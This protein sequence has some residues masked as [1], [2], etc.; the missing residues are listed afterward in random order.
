MSF[1]VRA[2]RFHLV[3]VRW[4]LYLT[5]FLFYIKTLSDEYFLLMFLFGLNVVY[6]FFYFYRLP[7]YLWI[8]MITWELV[9]DTLLVIET[10]QW[11]SPFVLYEYTTLLWL[12]TYLG[13]LWLFTVILLSLGSISVIPYFYAHRLLLPERSY[14][15][16]Q[17][18]L[19]TVLCFGGFFFLHYL[20]SQTK[21]LYRQ[22]LFLLSFLKRLART[23]HLVEINRL[24]EGVIKKLLGAKQAYVCWLHHREG[25][26][27]WVRAY[28]TFALVES[29]IIH[30]SS[31][32]RA[33]CITDYMG[34]L[35]QF[36][37]FPLIRRNRIIGAILISMESK[38]LIWNLAVLILHIIAISILN[39]ERYI[40]MRQE[41]ESAMHRE[42]RTKMAQDMHDGLAQQLF[43]L[44]AQIFHYKLNLP[45]SVPEQMKAAI[46][47][48]E[49]Q[50][51][52]C[53]LEVR[54]Y[55]H[56][57]RND[58]GEGH[59]FDAIEQLLH[60]LTKNSKVQVNYS[61]KGH[62]LQESLEVEETVYRF[63]EE[64]VYNVLKHAR[65]SILD[66]SLEV[67]SV[68]W[69]IRIK[70]DGVG[71]SP[72]IVEKKKESYGVMGMKDRMKRFGGVLSI[73]SQPNQG[74]EI[75]AIIP[76][77]GGKKYA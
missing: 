67:T 34:K 3:I 16:A 44:S 29:G 14:N 8:I 61:T 39:Q 28:Y 69:T 56:H 25:S 27:D 64:A 66:V 5:A 9:L 37:Y 22:I 30:N 75:V 19:Q 24:T 6:T 55:I 43:F 71:F 70:D 49:Q 58:R 38:K 20:I 59:I 41:M 32:P 54:G 23:K 45:P 12:G 11:N 50:V 7:R 18:V 47:K 72:E 68:Q 62:V 77:E 57:L 2:L 60:R 65:A 1:I 42:V 40:F 35:E 53:H 15:Q 63:T 10:G 31:K 36:F 33:Q 74:T 13:G 51:K 76:R 46:E 17:L 52:D 21:K 73:R 4:V 48:M 26:N